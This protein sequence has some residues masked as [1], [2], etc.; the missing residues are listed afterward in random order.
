MEFVPEL[1][2]VEEVRR[3]LEPFILGKRVAGV[4]VRRADVVT[5]VRAPLRGLVGRRFAGTFRHGKKLFVEAEDSQTLLFHLG[6]SGRIDCVAAAEPVGAHTHVI[7]HMQDGRDV[8]FRDP[9]RFGGVWY[10][11]TR[12]EAV[13]K[14]TGKLGPD[15]LQCRVEDFA[16]WR[17]TRGRL[18]MRLLSQRDI[19]GL[20]NIYVDEALWQ[21]QLHPMQRVG[22]IKPEQL[23]RMV[24][25]ILDVLGR[26]IASGG[27][28]LR[29]YRNVANQPGAFALQ[30]RA[31]GRAGLPCLRC[32]TV[33]RSS[34]TAGRTTVFCPQCQKQR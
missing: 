17:T 2:E 24:E 26:S 22:R 12:A 5:P 20:G 33:M 1:P 21:A 11:A 34:T 29:D 10:F 9:R 3:T 23:E 16:H 13:E 7:I 8:R 25:A 19:A 31:Y 18:K 27:T 30:L 4:S 14:E 32:D 28:T 15:A 6:M